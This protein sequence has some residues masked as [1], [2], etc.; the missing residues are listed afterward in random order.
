VKWDLVEHSHLFAL[1]PAGFS[2]F[3]SSSSTSP[4]H[5]KE[6][7]HPQPDRIFANP[8][9]GKMEGSSLVLAICRAFQVGQ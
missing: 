7:I 4:H 9:N 1:R 8:D 6:N 2:T 3:L 5:I